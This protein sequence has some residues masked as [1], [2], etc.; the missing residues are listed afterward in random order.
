MR[1]SI[2]SL[3][4]DWQHLSI[5]SSVS[6]LVVSFKYAYKRCMCMDVYLYVEWVLQQS[7]MHVCFLEFFVV[8]VFSVM[9]NVSLFRMLWWNVTSN[10]I[11]FFL[12]T[13]WYMYI[14]CCVV[15]VLLFGSPLHPVLHIQ[16][17]HYQIQHNNGILVPYN[18]CTN[19]NNIHN[20]N[21]NNITPQHTQQ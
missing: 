13:L 3:T 21:N 18:R 12:H 14:Y 16:L 17:W 20:N 5:S 8:F 1:G 15:R 9:L 6:S 7:R 19:T 4:N 10:P 2:P 11:F